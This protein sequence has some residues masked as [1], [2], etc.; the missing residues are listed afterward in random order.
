MNYY[1]LLGVTPQAGQAEIKSAFKQLALRYHPDRNPGN[2]EAEEKFKIINEAYHVLSDSIL[3]ARYDQKLFNQYSTEEERL[4]QAYREAARRRAAYQSR[5]PQSIYDRLGRFGWQ[6]GYTS[7]RPYKID[8]E[9]FKV[10]AYTLLLFLAIAG[11]IMGMVRLAD[12]L[13]KQEYLKLKQQ[14][15]LVMQQADSLFKHEQ[16]EKALSIMSDLVKKY[17]SEI[18]YIRAESSMIDGVRKIAEWEFDKHSYKN[19]A[20]KYI[21][22]LGYE[23]NQRISTWYRIS[24]CHHALGNYELSINALKQ[25]HKRDQNDIRVLL[26]IAQIYSRD[27]DQDSLA[28]PY[29]NQCKAMFINRMENSFGKAFE[30]V[31][32]PETLPTI[33]FDIFE[34]RA[35]S[36]IKLN[37]F[38]DAYTD[39]KWA[40]YLK[41]KESEMYY[42]RAVC[43]IAT[44]RN[45]QICEDLKMAHKLGHLAS[46]DLIRKY[47][48]S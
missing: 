21:L 45:Y 5:R 23:N 9:Y 3:K 15:D 25:I 32:R 48:S 20:D 6:D 34:G 35:K 38:E 41:P 47:C 31:I 11:S 40:L 1:E 44:G 24:E 22:L 4:E 37:N 7:S 36:N 2:P 39:C 16:Y 30:L 26:R 19:A 33:Y 46:N 13:K 14:N 27:L 8:K 29:F 42:L 28:L 18:N 12:Y 10:Q 17:P 43:R